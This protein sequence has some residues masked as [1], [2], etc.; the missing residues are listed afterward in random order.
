MMAQVTSQKP[1]ENLNQSESAWHRPEAFGS[2]SEPLAGFVADVAAG[3]GKRCAR[4]LH[5]RTD[6]VNETFAAS[7][8]R[9]AAISG[10]ATGNNVF[11]DSCVKALGVIT[12]CRNS[13][14]AQATKLFATMVLRD[15]EETTQK[16]QRVVE[17]ERRLCLVL[18]AT[19]RSIDQHTNLA[20]FGDPYAGEQSDQKRKKRAINENLHD[21]LWGSPFMDKEHI[22]GG[23][24][25]KKGSQ[26]FRPGSM[27]KTVEHEVILTSSTESK[28]PD[29]S[30]YT[31][32]PNILYYISVKDGENYCLALRAKT[33][34]GLGLSMSSHISTSVE[35]HAVIYDT[36]PRLLP[37]EP[38]KLKEQAIKV[39]LASGV[40]YLDPAMRLDLG[41]V[42]TIEYS[43]RAQQVGEVE[44]PTHLVAEWK[45]Q[46]VG[47]C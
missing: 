19:D 42:Y 29:Q 40:R 15:D 12:F 10:V 18:S 32:V 23:M 4:F 33:Y 46:M 26:F 7:T 24:F 34:G 5:E 17:E 27:F 43:I 47:E 14:R 35:S 30:H 20:Y 38:D 11:A 31:V 28:V 36:E 41:R 37:G 13:S 22:I 3:N 16:F 1:L 44:K 25:Q 45:R 9:Q 6:A 39:C 21:L 2:L 8:L